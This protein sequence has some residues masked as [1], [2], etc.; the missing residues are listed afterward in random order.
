[1]I[2]V[3]ILV[4]NMPQLMTLDNMAPADVTTISIRAINVTPTHPPPFLCNVS[5][6]LLSSV[7]LPSV[8][9]SSETYTTEK[10]PFW[11]D[12]SRTRMDYKQRI[13]KDVNIF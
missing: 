6:N 4:A 2:S 13:N 10:V 5:H 12:L 7:T 9:L 1:M 3:A 11:S 8:Y